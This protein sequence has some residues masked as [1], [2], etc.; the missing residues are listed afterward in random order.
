[1]LHEGTSYRAST[2][3]RNL[4]LKDYPTYDNPRAVKFAGPLGTSASEAARGG[5]KRRKVN[6]SFHV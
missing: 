5:F 3:R 2:E 6:F 4:P 1:V